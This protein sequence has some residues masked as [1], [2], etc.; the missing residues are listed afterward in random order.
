[1]KLST[2]PVVIFFYLPFFRRLNITTAYEFLEKRFGL[3]TRLYGSLTFII[4]QL[5][6]MAIVTYLPALALSAITLAQLGIG[7]ADSQTGPTANA[8]ISASAISSGR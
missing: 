3:I 4:F 6:R 2:I 5:L 1:M 8:A 7:S